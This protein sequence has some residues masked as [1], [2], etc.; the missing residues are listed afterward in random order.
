MEGFEAALKQAGLA[1]YRIKREAADQAKHLGVRLATMHRVKGPEFEH[2]LVVSANADVIPLAKAK[3]VAAAD[4]PLS[5]REAETV[6]RALL[7]VAL[8]R[9]K[10]LASDSAFGIEGPFLVAESA[11]STAHEG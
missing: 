8:T 9:T 3:A 10:K 2:I 1:V 4:D 11:K 5:A 7:Y 6:E